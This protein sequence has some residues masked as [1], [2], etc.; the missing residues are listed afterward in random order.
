M[1]KMN[2][3]LQALVEI[4]KFIKDNEEA[5][6]RKDE[7]LKRLKGEDNV[8]TIVSVAEN[9]IE[10]QKDIIKIKLDSD[11]AEKVQIVDKELLNTTVNTF[12]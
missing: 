11:L 6:L 3:E 8:I 10:S 7:I 12:L 9:F 5:K 2:W 1:R 4:L